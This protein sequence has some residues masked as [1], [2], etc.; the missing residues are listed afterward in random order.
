MSALNW[1]TSEYTIST[2]YSMLSELST[3]RI[4]CDPIGQR[5]DIESMSKRQGIIDTVIRGYD[6]GELKMRTLN[7]ILQKE[8]GYNFRSID[9]GHRKR[10]VRDFIQNKFKTGK[11]TVAIVDGVEVPVGGLYY[12]QLPVEVKNQFNSYKMRFTVY[13]ESMT[14]EQ[15]GETFRRTNISTDV[16]WQEMLNSYEDNLVAKFVRELSRPIRGIENEYHKLF[17]YKVMEPEN[18]K[19]T[20]FQ[21][22]S[23]RLRDDEFVTR[24]LTMLTKSEK[25]KNWLT[26]SNRENENTFVNLGDPIKGIW[27]KDKTL[28]KRQQKMVRD[29]LDF[30]L[31]YAKAK[32][33]Y[34]KQ[35]MSTQEFTM[36]SRL[37]V[38][39]YRT[40][41]SNGYRISDVTYFYQSVRA[42]MDRFVG[43]DE[44]NLRED[45]HRDNKGL[46]TVCECFRQYLT[47]H[48]DEAKSENSVK[49]LLQEMDIND[50]GITFLDTVRTFS[51]ELIEQVLRQQGYK[52]WVTGYPLSI[53]DAVGAHIVAH[54]LGGS[55]QDPNN[56]AVTHKDENTRM[57]TMDAILYR[58]IRRDELKLAA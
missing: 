23:T 42:A 28:A 41:G 48:D 40:F 27:S 35:L 49:W 34:S 15:A 1:T 50:C 36:V 19:Q 6:F 55:S 13:G 47:V 20:Y 52:C 56:C 53:E 21:S 58:Q 54:T 33:S 18:R 51:P 43:R 7:A 45:T 38:Y 25:D 9:G 4:D 44:R 10:A 14:D 3:A 24:F 2:F 26:C 11:Y 46:R 12:S 57:G 31:E 17:D 32:R 5:P 39:L 30:M 8:C 37:Y 29:A 16:N 22:A